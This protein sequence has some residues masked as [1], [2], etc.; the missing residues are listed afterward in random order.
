MSNI[1]TVTTNSAIKTPSPTGAATATAGSNSSL[2]KDAF[3][4]LM[5]AQM[6]YQDPSKP[7]DGTAFLA[8][9]AQFTNIELLQKLQDSQ[10]TLLSFQSVVLSSSLVGKTV[11][12][13]TLDGSTVS[14]KVDSAQV[15]AGNG[16]L[17]IGDKRIPVTGVTEVK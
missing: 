9:T 15:V 11:T 1:D 8:Q 6:R 13:T 10:Q 16:F 7:M 14:G 12:G 5:V 4:K 3:M 17:M 2:D